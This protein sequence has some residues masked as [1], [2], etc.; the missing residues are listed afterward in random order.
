MVKNILNI[1]QMI[2]QGGR[3]T[4]STCGIKHDSKAQMFSNHYKDYAEKDNTAKKQS[5]DNNI[6][7]DIENRRE[8]SG[9]AVHEKKSKANYIENENIQKKAAKRI[10]G[11]EDN[12]ND[13]NQ[14]TSL[15]KDKNQRNTIIIN[16]VVENIDN[17]RK[18]LFKHIADNSSIEDYVNENALIING[19]NITQNTEPASN[20]LLSENINIA[21][22]EIN[23]INKQNNIV[24]ESENENPNDSV[25]LNV[26]SQAINVNKQTTGSDNQANTK[27][28]EKTLHYDFV[29]DKQSSDVFVKQNNDSQITEQVIKESSILIS[30][31][32]NKSDISKADFNNSLRPD[33]I[34]CNIFNN[35]NNVAN[36]QYTNMEDADLLL[37]SEQIKQKQSKTIIN[38]NK[39]IEQII[40]DSNA[41]TTGKTN[42]ILD[43]KDASIIKDNSSDISS[44]IA[45]QITESIHSS[46]NSQ[47]SQRQ[48]TIRLNPPELGSV[49]VKFSENEAQLSGI[50]EVS[51]A[52]TK[53]EIEQALPQI[54]RTLSDSGIQLKRVEVISS[55]TSHMSSDAEQEL[56]YSD[57]QSNQNDSMNQQYD[58]GS[59]NS[60]GF[61]KW[62]S[63]TIEYRQISGFENQ[64]AGSGAVN[65]LA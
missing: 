44:Q 52:Q 23:A 27:S 30:Q 38:D 47:T 55:D 48:I 17:F 11:C 33:N 2:S 21:E 62:F 58:T 32:N 54:L 56:F 60:S 65:M 14:T 13:H 18:S 20:E 34:N 5:P 43:A 45:K 61:N 4:E 25:K 41:S 12:N 50:L 6:D 26:E 29:I 1:A 42:V 57:N 15:S 9:Y 8:R 53:F 64:Y 3:Q 19:Q 39:E 35:I 40:A 46:I 49:V 59:S 63:N 37:T 24:K 51:K 10:K 16:D 28:N 36:A 7:R 22:S 31:S